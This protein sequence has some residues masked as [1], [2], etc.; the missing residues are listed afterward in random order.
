M[1]IT[2][3]A[4]T[5]R[6]PTQWARRLVAGSVD[7]VLVSVAGDSRQTP[8]AFVPDFR[9]PAVEAISLGRRP[10]LLLHSPSLESSGNSALGPGGGGAQRGAGGNHR[11]PPQ[12]YLLPPRDHQPC[13]HQL[14]GA[15][16]GCAATAA[17]R[18]H[19]ADDYPLAWCRPGAVEPLELRQREAF[20]ELDG[21]ARHGLTGICVPVYT[22][23]SPC[24]A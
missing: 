19:L 20:L 13:L 1:P 2:P 16:G 5:F 18:S 10:L 3:Q 4:L 6:T 11:W 9:N 14:A 15:A 12:G 22:S 21:T 8:A 23:S 24:A 7:A 17:R